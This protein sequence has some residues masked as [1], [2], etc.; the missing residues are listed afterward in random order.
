MIQQNMIEY[1]VRQV[2]KGILEQ[3][4]QEVSKK[5]IDKDGY[6]SLDP[7]KDYPLATKRPELVKTPTG[8]SL[9]E[10]TLENVVDGV[11]KAEDLRI[12]PD[13]LRMQAEIAQKVGRTQFANN[14]RR[15]SELTA[16]PDQRILEIYNALRPYRS[17]KQE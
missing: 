12:T 13:T 5:S 1:V 14:L 7:N 16:I 8:K 2:L 10:I 9:N 17:K 4:S 15:A 6:G 3:D 11:I